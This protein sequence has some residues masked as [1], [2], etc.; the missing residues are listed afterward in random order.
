LAQQSS[1]V[2]HLFNYQS[3]PNSQFLQAFQDQYK[4]PQ[5]YDGEY[6][7]QGTQHKTTVVAPESD[8]LDY[9]SGAD[10]RYS[11]SQSGHSE[12]QDDAASEHLEDDGEL[13]SEADSKTYG[14][15]IAPKK[16]N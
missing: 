4:F 7:A 3:D 15:R 14:Q 10:V 16:K 2:S 6:H 9:D 8:E 11:Y 5:Q 1:P 13:I 12:D